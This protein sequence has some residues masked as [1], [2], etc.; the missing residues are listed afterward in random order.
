MSIVAEDAQLDLPAVANLG[1]SFRGR[2][3]RPGDADY[4]AASISPMWSTTH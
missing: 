1:R 4:D 3:V 2:V